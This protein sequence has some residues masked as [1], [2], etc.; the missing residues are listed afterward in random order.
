MQVDYI[1][2]SPLDAIGSDPHAVFRLTFI[3]EN[4][5]LPD[6]WFQSAWPENMQDQL[7]RIGQTPFLYPIQGAP[8]VVDDSNHGKAAVIDCMARSAQGSAPVQVA[9]QAVQDC[10]GYA[11]VAR[12]EKL[13][14]VSTST[15][16]DR[17]AEQ[18]ATAQQVASDTAAQSTS[19]T[20][21][22]YAWWTLF[23]LVV[24]VVGLIVWKAPR[25]GGE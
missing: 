14:A 6:S 1:S 11:N 22:K 2:C 7:E 25:A 5:I 18:E 10:Y 17:P 24:V 21:K 15:V 8:T 20:I 9:V 16:E 23:A 19:A 12:V 3:P 4:P 13:G